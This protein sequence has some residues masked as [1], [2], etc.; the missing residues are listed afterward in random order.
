MSEVFLPGVGQ[1]QQRVDHLTDL[2]SS[3]D[4]ASDNQVFP[5]IVIVSLKTLHKLVAKFGGGG[6]VVHLIAKYT[7]LMK[8]YGIYLSICRSV[9]QQTG[10][11]QTNDL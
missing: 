7:L 10:S 2:F 8:S 4:S 5:I 1:F 3:F 9:L 6:G 11:T